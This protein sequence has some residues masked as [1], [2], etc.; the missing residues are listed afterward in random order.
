MRSRRHSSPIQPPSDLQLSRHARERMR[1]RAIGDAELLI[2][3][4]VARPAHHL[5][6]V[7]YLVTDRC[8]RG[9]PWARLADRL[10]GLCVVIAPD[11]VVKTVKWHYR[12]RRRAGV[13]RRG[14]AAA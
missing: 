6:D 1:Q 8:L 10:R 3:L 13:L 7:L 14:N 9:T 4:A 5:G 11:G 2:A 12:T